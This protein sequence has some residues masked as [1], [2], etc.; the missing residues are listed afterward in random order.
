MKSIDCLNYLCKHCEKITIRNGFVGCP[1]RCISNDFCEEYEI[2]MN[3]LK[4]L[5]ELKKGGFNNA[6]LKRR[7]Q[8]NK[9]R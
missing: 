3:D 1:Y 5:E 8:K 2:I 7:N 9:E 6:N 4:L